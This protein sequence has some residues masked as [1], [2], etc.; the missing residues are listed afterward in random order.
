[1][2]RVFTESEKIFEQGIVWMLEMKCRSSACATWFYHIRTMSSKAS[3]EDGTAIHLKQNF[4]GDPPSFG[5][6]LWWIFVTLILSMLVTLTFKRAS[7]LIHSKTLN[8]L[9]WISMSQHPQITNYLP[10]KYGMSM[11][12][13]VMMYFRTW[14]HM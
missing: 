10:L 4:T 6:M 1:M 7:T 12:Q 2:V 9:V 11:C 8:G 3:Q 13:S 14:E 5:Q